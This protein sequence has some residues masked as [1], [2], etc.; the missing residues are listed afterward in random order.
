MSSASP[1]ALSGWPS[2]ARFPADKKLKRLNAWVHREYLRLFER[3]FAEHWPE[4]PRWPAA[5]RDQV[6]RSVVTF[7]NGMTA[8]HRDQPARLAG[9]A[10]RSS[11][12]GCSWSCCGAGPRSA[13]S[14][15][16]RLTGAAMDFS[17]SDEQQL[18]VKT[19]RDFVRNELYPHEKEVEETGVLRAELQQRA[20][21]QGHRGRP[22]R[23]QHADGGGRRRP[24]H[25]HLGAVREGARAIPTTRCIT[26]ASGVPRTSCW[27]AR[28]SS[29]SATCC[30][31]CAASE[32]SAWR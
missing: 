4:W 7:I 27:P 31:P 12:C 29:A 14:G 16:G 21:G 6:L 5:V 1:N 19:T 32:S 24:G 30:R 18:I 13:A 22:V 28:A 11:S 9:R 23:G 8:E 15:T 3:C 2:G 20:Q 25:G 26:P 10:R 17:L